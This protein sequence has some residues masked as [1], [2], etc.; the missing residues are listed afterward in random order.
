MNCQ[1]PVWREKGEGLRTFSRLISRIF[2]RRSRGGGFQVLGGVETRTL[3]AR[4]AAL[5]FV[6]GAFTL[7][8]L[9]VVIAIIAIL[10]AMLLPT[11]SRA[12]IKAK[13]NQC[14][15]NLRQTVKG[16][17]N[18]QVGPASPRRPL[19]SFPSAAPSLSTA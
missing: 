1:C 13:C 19:E 14:K 10:A 5:P 16:A 2:S 17:W 9:L 3:Q 8:E 4:A 15:S 11:F 18:Y 6:R 12:K 7:I